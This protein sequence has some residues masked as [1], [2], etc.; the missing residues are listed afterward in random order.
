M[1]YPEFNWTNI[2]ILLGII[3]F[4][5]VLPHLL[6]GNAVGQINDTFDEIFGRDRLYP[7]LQEDSKIYRLAKIIVLFICMGG[8]VKIMLDSKK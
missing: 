8:I 5:I 3:A 4:L 1:K 7:P 2:V 6:D